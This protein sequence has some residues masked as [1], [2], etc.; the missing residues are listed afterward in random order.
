MPSLATRPAWWPMSPRVPAWARGGSLAT[1]MRPTGR[2]APPEVPLGLGFGSA[3]VGNFLAVD[4]IRSGRFLDT[5]EFTPFHDIGN[6]ETI[7]DHLR[8]RA[9]REGLSPPQPVRRAQLDSDSQRLRPVDAGPAPAR[10]HLERRPG[11]PAHL[12]RPH[13]ADHQSVYPQGRVLLLRQP[14]PVRRHAGHPESE[15]PV[16]ELGREERPLA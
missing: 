9:R 7:F 1:S 12:Q 13:P 10:A 11:L 6:N 15:P 2:S 4:G 14:R 5:P 8:L 16:A 3:K